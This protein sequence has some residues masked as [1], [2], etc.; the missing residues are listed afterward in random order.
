MTRR[1]K[2]LTLGVRLYLVRADGFCEMRVQARTPAGA[3]YQVF[4]L[5][6]EAGYF[7]S[8]RG[9][10]RDFID[11]G[12]VARELARPAGSATFAEPDQPPETIR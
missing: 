1:A 4:K 6:R 11:R 7:S 10:F 5:A 3:K 12:W 2:Q 8:S 9:G